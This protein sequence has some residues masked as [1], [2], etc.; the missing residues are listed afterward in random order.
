[1]FAERFSN[2][3][4]TTLEESWLEEG[5]A[6]HSEELYA[7]IFSGAAWKGNTG[8]GSSSAPNYIWCE[9]RPSTAA[10]ADRPLLV[11]Q[12]FGFLYDYLSDIENRTVAGSVPGD[13]NDVSFYGSAWA[14]VR[15]MIDAYATN[16]GAVLRALTTE[17]S[18]SGAANLAARSGVSYDEMLPL[19]HYA[20]RYD[21]AAG[22][23]S[24]APWQHIASWNFPNVFGGLHA[25]FQT[26]FDADYLL[27]HPLQFGSFGINI[28]VLR[29]GTAAHFEISGS[30]TAKQVLVLQAQNGAAP[31][32]ALRMSV[33]RVQ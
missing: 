18:L 8:Y 14:F 33:F 5:M 23:T 32:P 1:M 28:N 26:V 11:T 4:A 15:W 30:Q 25:D 7:R 29:G 31:D 13:P 10:C 6:M 27:D 16:E 24:S 3:N 19:F 12:A 9:V 2:A 22:V 20:L 21:D 17:P